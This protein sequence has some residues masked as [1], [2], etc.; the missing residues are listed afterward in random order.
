MS[1]LEGKV[2]LVTRDADRYEE[3]ASILRARDAR[4]LSAPAIQIDPV[5]VGGPLDE[6]IRDTAMRAHAWVVF[7]SGAGVRAW[8]ERAASL[9]FDARDLNAHVAA[10]GTGTA[11][12]L[13]AHGVTADLVPPAFTTEELGAAFPEGGG[14]V[15]LAR[16]DIA[17]AGLEEQLAAKGWEPVRVDAYRSRHA[18]TLPAEAAAALE[19]GQVDAITFTSRSTVLGFVEI[20]G[21][22][23]GPA[24]VC[25]GPVTEAAAREAGLEVSATADPHTLE[26]L[27]EA[28]ERALA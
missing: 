8:F 28:L 22:V 15:L 10:I 21:S 26:G 17:P 13:E 19:A 20:A 7:T 27:V 5:P 1:A 16:A 11:R 9:G 2:V 12:E 3:L 14:T 25:I 6:A 4:P 18:E 24:V 23:R